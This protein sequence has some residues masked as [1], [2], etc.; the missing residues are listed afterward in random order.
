MMLAMT[1]PWPLPAVKAWISKT[2]FKDKLGFVLGISLQETQELIGVVGCGTYDP[3]SIMYALG[4]D[5]WGTGYAS[6]ALTA[7]LPAL[8]GRFDVKQFYADA[9]LDNPGSLRVL[10]KAGF[11]RTHMDLGVSAARAQPALMQCY[12]WTASPS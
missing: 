2:S 11:K 6:E 1:V 10:E 12:L 7:F 5:Y 8:S 3:P 9:F 4:K